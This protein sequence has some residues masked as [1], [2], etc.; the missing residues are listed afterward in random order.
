MLKFNILLTAILLSLLTLAFYQTA[1]ADF[2]P[3]VVIAFT[4]EEETK[5]IVTD[6]SGNGN[7]AELK[8]SEITKDGKYGSGLLVNG[9]SNDIVQDSPEL[10][11]T[12]KMRIFAWV[13]V[14]TWTNWGRIGEKGTWPNFSYLML[15]RDVQGK[16]GC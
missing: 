5:G 11:P 13:Q 3:D 15:L 10:N 8:G 6:I 7:D 2:P 9:S 16:L 1:F 12:D 4:F 14:N